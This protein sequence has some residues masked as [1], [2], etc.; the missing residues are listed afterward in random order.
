MLLLFCACAKPKMKIEEAKITTQ[1]PY[2]K[3]AIRSTALAWN[4]FHSK[5]KIDSLSAVYADKIWL[6]GR[7]DLP[8]AKGIE[9]KRRDLNKFSTYVQTIDSLYI[10]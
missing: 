6:F 2:Y 5:E 9:V 7:E 1:T 10:R 8:K 4:R 3:Y